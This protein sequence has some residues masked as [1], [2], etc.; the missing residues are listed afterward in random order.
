MYQRKKSVLRLF[1]KSFLLLLFMNYMASVS[2]FTHSH[3]VNG[4][5]IIHSH[6]YPLNEKGADHQHTGTQLQ[7]IGLLS[8]FYVVG[9]IVLYFFFTC[10]QYIYNVLLTWVNPFIHPLFQCYFLFSRPPPVL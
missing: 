3:V 4:V 8:T 10:F 5:T 9:S 1:I 7:L 2:F 6:P